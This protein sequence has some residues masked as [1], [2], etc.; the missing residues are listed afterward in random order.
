MWMTRSEQMKRKVKGNS[1]V[2]WVNSSKYS[3]AK[4]VIWRAIVPKSSMK[5]SFAV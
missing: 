2:E 1:C 3:I 5:Y 4:I